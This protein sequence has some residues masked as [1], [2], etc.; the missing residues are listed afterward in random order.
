MQRSPLSIRNRFD[1][2]GLYLSGLCALHCVLGIVLVSVLGLGSG[3]LM[4][5]EIHQIGLGLAVVVGFLSLG[6][7][8]FRHGRIGPLM[9]GVTGLC[10]MA[11]ALF[12]GHGVNEA[13]LTIGGVGLVAAAHLWNLRGAD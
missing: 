5:P 4:A 10:Q 2:A 1:R 3:A 8:F 7:G 9:L 11:G 13:V 6:L 12:V